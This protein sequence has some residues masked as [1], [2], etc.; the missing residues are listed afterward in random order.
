VDAA[1]LE[2]SDPAKKRTKTEH[3]SL[4]LCFSE[5]YAAMLKFTIN[6]LETLDFSHEKTA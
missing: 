4:F 2:A 3:N 5:R 6:L 1:Q